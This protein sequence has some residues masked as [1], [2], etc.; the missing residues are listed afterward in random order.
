MTIPP[1]HDIQLARAAD[2]VTAT[3]ILGSAF[4]HDLL[5]NWLSER[6]EIYNDLF[7][8]AAESLYKQHHCVYLNRERSGAAMWLPPGI[9]TKSNLHWRMLLLGWKLRKGGF[10]RL[11]ARGDALDKVTLAE[12]PAEPHFYLHSIGA[13]LGHQGRGI[14]SALLKAGLNAC[15]QQGAIAYLESTNIK[16]NPLYERYGFE[17]VGDATLP[18]SGPTIW[19]MKRAAQQSL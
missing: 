12:H 8:I 2:M 9:S 19:F 6:P 13:S 18:D 5:L 1:E 4:S 17:V 15:D 10:K 11:L 16:N 14:G 7:R 3:N